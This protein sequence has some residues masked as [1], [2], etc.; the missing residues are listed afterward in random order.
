MMKFVA[1]PGVEKTQDK[2]KQVL[3]TELNAARSANEQAKTMGHE[4][5]KALADARAKA[6]ATIGDIKAEAAKLA[7]EQQAAQS[8]QLNARL[9]DAE[10]SIAKARDAALKDVDATASD[11]AAAIVERMKAVG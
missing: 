5:D 1:L 4:A 11:L 7:A 6:A 10:A 3:D 8:K 9:R 2:R